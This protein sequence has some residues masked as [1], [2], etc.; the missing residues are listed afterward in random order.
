MSINCYSYVFVQRIIIADKSED[1]WFKKDYKPP[2]FDQNDDVSLE[3]VDAVFNS[4]EVIH[5]ECHL[6]VC[7]LLSQ[8]IMF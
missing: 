5:S 4:S 8:N 2:H 1:E 7:S 6:L 3:D